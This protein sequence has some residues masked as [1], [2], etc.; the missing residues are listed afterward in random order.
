LTGQGNHNRK[1]AKKKECFGLKKGKKINIRKDQKSL[2]RNRLHPCHD[3][4]HMG[5]TAERVKKFGGEKYCCQVGGGGE[6]WKE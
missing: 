3:E 2:H 4:E 1:G 6:A 5:G